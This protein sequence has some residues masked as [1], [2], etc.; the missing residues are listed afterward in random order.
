MS[1]RVFEFRDNALRREIPVAFGMP[2]QPNRHQVR[3]G[4]RLYLTADGSRLVP[5]GHPEARYLYCTANTL[6]SKIE[7]ERLLGKEAT[8]VEAIR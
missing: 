2:K 1:N 8:D 5:Q 6:V 7:Y 4:R 3:P